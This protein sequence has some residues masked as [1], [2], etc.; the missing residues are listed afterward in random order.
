MKPGLI[1]SESAKPG[2]IAD[3]AF[4]IV[5]PASIPEELGSPSIPSPSPPEPPIEP[6]WFAFALLD[7]DGD[8][9]FAGVGV[10]NVGVGAP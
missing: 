2:A 5:L 10:K 9:V 7:P 1:P 4:A 3:I 8:V 6:G